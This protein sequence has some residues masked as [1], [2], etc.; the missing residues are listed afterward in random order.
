MRAKEIAAEL[1]E[2]RTFID[3]DMVRILNQL[4]KVISAIEN[5]EIEFNAAGH[6][7]SLASLIS[8]YENECGYD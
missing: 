7:V 3:P 6:E 8:T 1:K 2:I 5:Q 4:D